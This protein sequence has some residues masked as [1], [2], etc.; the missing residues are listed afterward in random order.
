MKFS[1][2]DETSLERWLIYQLEFYEVDNPE[3]LSKYILT[4]LKNDKPLSQLES[5]FEGE[6]KTFLKSKTQDFVS[7]LITSVNG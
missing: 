5:Y 1:R 3:V 6:L 4:L 2:E 7:F